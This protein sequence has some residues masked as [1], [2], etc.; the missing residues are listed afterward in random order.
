M[1]TYLCMT[2]AFLSLQWL[3]FLL[4][5]LLASSNPKSAAI[6]WFPISSASCEGLL[7]FCNCNVDTGY[8]MCKTIATWQKGG[9]L[10]S[11]L[12]L[13]SLASGKVSMRH[14][15]ISKFPPSTAMCTAVRPATCI[16]TREMGVEKHQVIGTV[17]SNVLFTHISFVNV[18]SLLN[19]ISTQKCVEHVCVSSLDCQHE[20][21]L[22]V[23]VSHV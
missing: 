13:T 16:H 21:C 2:W 9:G 20:S 12:S 11:T 18:H 15:I 7:S 10:F 23:L 4:L 3:L 1:S 5:L 6:S 14:L 22:V 19:V 17:V 8:I